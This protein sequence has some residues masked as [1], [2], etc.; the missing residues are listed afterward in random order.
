MLPVYLSRQGAKPIVKSILQATRPFIC[1]THFHPL[2]QKVCN[3][4]EDKEKNSFKQTFI[5]ITLSQQNPRLLFFFTFYSY[6]VLLYS[7]PAAI[8]TLVAKYLTVYYLELR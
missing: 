2:Y 6:Q 4:K 8:Q 3:P 1:D 5:Y 7:A